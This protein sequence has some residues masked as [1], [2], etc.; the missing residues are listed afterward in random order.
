MNDFRTLSSPDQ[1][2]ICLGLSRRAENA[3]LRN[4][5]YTVFDLQNLTTEDIFNLRGVGVTCANEIIR[6]GFLGGNT[7]S[8]EKVNLPSITEYMKQHELQKDTAIRNYHMFVRYF[9]AYPEST[10]DELANHENITRSRAGQ[11]I[12]RTLEHISSLIRKRQI[13]GDF[14]QLAIEYAKNMTRTDAVIINADSILNGTALIVIASE[15]APEQVAIYSNPRYLNH[16]WVVANKDQ[17]NT[18]LESLMNFLSESPTKH[19]IDELSTSFRLNK[20]LIL[21]IKS[22]A[23]ENGAITLKGNRAA[24]GE[25]CEGIIERCLEEVNGPVHL[26]DIAKNTGR[27]LNQIRSCIGRMNSIKNVGQSVYVLKDEK[28]EN[29]SV[30]ELVK[31]YLLAVRRPAMIPKVISY[32]QEYKNIPEE[33]IRY[34]LF[35]PSSIF[36]KRHGYMRIWIKG[37]P[38]NK[39]DDSRNYDIQIDNAV[40]WIFKNNDNPLNKE[41][42]RAYIKATFGNKT[43][44]NMVS[45]YSAMRRLT[46]KEILRRVG[47]YNSGLYMKSR[48]FDDQILNSPQIKNDFL[49]FEINLPY[50]KIEDERQDDVALHT[51]PLNKSTRITKDI[52]KQVGG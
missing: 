23:A 25:S 48:D 45:I 36:E 14:V 5:V 29:Q 26:S 7:P 34:V 46:N 44:H 1:S 39:S 38:Y 33:S 35:N 18:S 43:T 21:D 19:T 37:M 17:V 49:Y 28:F 41:T 47:D 13:N 31:R 3:L 11:I 9:N 32:V 22:I 15:V 50:Q 2:I 6:L 10:Y 24:R 30:V 42:V 51:I 27:T 8:L 12:T 4:G 16:R 20:A 52:V 40:L